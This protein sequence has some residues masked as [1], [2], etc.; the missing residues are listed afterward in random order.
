MPTIISIT[1]Y[2]S[3][4]GRYKWSVKQGKKEFFGEAGQ[5]PEA[6]A[7]TAVDK[8]ITFGETDGY[9]IFAPKSVL[10]LIPEDLRHARSA[11]RPTELEKGREAN[12]YLDAESIAIATRL[13]N[14]NVSEGIRKALKQAGAMLAVST[15]KAN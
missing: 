1:E 8:A 2:S 7:A 6:A 4:P 14:G 12:T 15:T 10:A 5:G 9:S 13:G 3:M 11:G